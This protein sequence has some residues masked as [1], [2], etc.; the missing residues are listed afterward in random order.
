MTPIATSRA[1]VLPQE[2]SNGYTMPA[3]RVAAPGYQPTSWFASV[4]GARKTQLIQALGG[5]TLYSLLSKTKSKMVICFN[6]DFPH[7]QQIFMHASCTTSKIPHFLPSRNRY[8]SRFG[9]IRHICSSRTKYTS[10]LQV[11]KIF[12]NKDIY[13]A[14]DMIA[15]F[16]FARKCSRPVAHS[17]TTVQGLKD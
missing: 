11:G 2:D 8:S 15:L 17:Y 12:P 6:G 4:G 1:G 14:Q 9:A 7:S 16:I 5:T 10:S 3:A 13:P